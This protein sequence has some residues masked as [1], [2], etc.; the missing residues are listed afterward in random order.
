MVLVP[1]S[2]AA[3]G[4]ALAIKQKISATR[5]TKM[6]DRAEDRFTRIAVPF[7]FR[8]A[9]PS[10]DLSHLRCRFRSGCPMENPS[11]FGSQRVERSEVRVLMVTL[12]VA[13]SKH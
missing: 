8:E 13:T 10:P 2:C 12:R 9:R 5:G 6:R 7:R 1:A 11:G 4:V 3:S